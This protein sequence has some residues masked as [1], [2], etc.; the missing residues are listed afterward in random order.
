MIRFFVGPII[1]G[2]LPLWAD[3]GEHFSDLDRV[4][5][6]VYRRRA[7]NAV[8]VSYSHEDRVIVD[9]LE[10]AY[11]VLGL[12]YV[13]DIRFLRSG[14]E[15]SET[16]LHKIPGADVFQ[17]CWSNAAKASANVEREWRCALKLGRSEFI[18]PMYWQDPMPVPPSELEHFHFARLP[19]GG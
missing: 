4:L 10:E 8:F 12:D 7:Y 16:L 11:T 14:N 13:R 9:R 1:V 2:D 5:P 17:L 15:W 19:I 6:S 3:V 18:R